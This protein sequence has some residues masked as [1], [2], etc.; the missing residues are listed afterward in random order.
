VLVAGF[1]TG[2]YDQFFAA[3]YRAERR[4]LKKGDVPAASCGW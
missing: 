4:P 1:N 2:G 3:H